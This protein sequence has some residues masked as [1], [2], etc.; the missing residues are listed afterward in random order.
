MPRCWIPHKRHQS[1]KTFK[2]N[3]IEL[4]KLSIVTSLVSFFQVHV[5]PSGGKKNKHLYLNFPSTPTMTRICKLESTPTRRRREKWNCLLKRMKKFFSFLSSAC[6]TDGKKVVVAQSVCFMAAIS[7][8][9]G[10]TIGT[11]RDRGSF[12]PPIERRRVDRTRVR[13]SFA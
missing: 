6:A 7:G 4:V 8:I 11:P 2:W 10:H 3:T 1:T 12:W 9:P 13:A 5:A